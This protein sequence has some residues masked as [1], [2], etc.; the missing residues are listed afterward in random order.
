MC[1]EVGH[2]SQIQSQ[3]LITLIQ[4]PGKNVRHLNAWRPRN[5]TNVDA[6]ILI[7]NQVLP[8][9]IISETQA[10]F[11]YVRYNWGPIRL[12]SDLLHGTEKIKIQRLLFSVDIQAAF[13][14]IDLCTVSQ[15]LKEFKFNDYCIHL[16]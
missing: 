11:V 7:A 1:W 15:V 4:K 14:S 2:L 3:A 10:A 5:L 16:I 6:R 13:D 9:L 12:L 8:L